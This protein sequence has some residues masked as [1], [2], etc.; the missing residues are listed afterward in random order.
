MAFQCDIA[1][2]LTKASI[3]PKTTPS[4]AIKT[5]PKQPA[6]EEKPK[7]KKESTPEISLEANEKMSV[8]DDVGECLDSKFEEYV[9]LLC[10]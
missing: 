1:R 2:D 6:V 3:P 10:Y 9:A 8:D 4:V 5:E 7:E